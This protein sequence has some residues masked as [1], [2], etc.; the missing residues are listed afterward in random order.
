MACATPGTG[1][2]E[3]YV[4]HRDDRALHGHAVQGEHGKNTP[5]AHPIIS[6]HRRQASRAPSR[7]HQEIQEFL[8]DEF[9][10][11]RTVS[12]LCHRIQESLQMLFDHAVQHA[13][14]GR[15]LQAGRLRSGTS[16][17]GPRALTDSVSKRASPTSST[18]APG[19]RVIRTE[20]GAA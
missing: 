7:R 6:P 13:A 17:S 8:F 15:M 5:M 12:V 9:P 18:P 14:F 10:Q 2:D 11:A 1:E 4:G 3:A 16:A 20:P 19:W